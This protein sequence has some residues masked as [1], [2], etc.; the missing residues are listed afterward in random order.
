ME[1]LSIN[2]IRKRFF[3]IG[4]KLQVGVFTAG[5]LI[6]AWTVLTVFVLPTEIDDLLSLF[7]IDKFM[8][9]AGGFFAAA[10]L[11]IFLAI[12]KRSKLIYAVIAI[13]ILWEIWEIIFLPDQFLRFKAYPALWVTDTFFDLIADI[14]GSYFFAETIKIKQE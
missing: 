7:Q 9:F 4:Q 11:L 13:G 8:H 12:Q 3:G 2:K 1:I 10:L 14:L 5:V 6:I